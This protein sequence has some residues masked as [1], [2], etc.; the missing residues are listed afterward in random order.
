MSNSSRSP[1]R[2]AQ[3]QER[4]DKV[5]RFA[6]QNKRWPSSVAADPEERFL[7]KWFS[8]SRYY[9]DQ[10]KKNKRF[11]GIEDHTAEKIKELIA[12]FPALER[13]NRWESKFH[14]LE[15]KILA[16]R[17]IWPITKATPEQVKLINWWYKQK[18][19]VKLFRSGK[20]VPSMNDERAKKIEKLI[21]YTYPALPYLI[22]RLKFKNDYCSDSLDTKNKDK[23]GPQK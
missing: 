9:I 16:S 4:I 11:K 21:E 10:K 8:R 15:L 1:R 3:L 2:L 5:R 18:Q 6:E 19:N 17:K 23:K 12:K 14:R 13:F 20:K 7:G 22:H